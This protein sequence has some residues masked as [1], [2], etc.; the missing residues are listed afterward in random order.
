MKN[1]LLQH[2]QRLRNVAAMR[3]RN[4]ESGLGCGSFAETENHTHYLD[5][6]FAPRGA[7]AGE[8][9]AYPYSESVRRSPLVSFSRLAAMLL[10]LITMGICNALGASVTWEKVTSAP[11]DWSGEYLIVYN[12]QAYDGSLTSNFDASNNYQSV[13]IKDGKITLDDTYSF[14]LAAVTGGYSLQNAAGYYLGRNANSNGMDNA[15]TYNS[16]L[17]ITITWSSTNKNAKLA[18]KGGRCLGNNSGRWRFF[19]SSNAYVNVDLYKKAAT[20]S[21]KVALTKGE[22]N[23]GSFNCTRKKLRF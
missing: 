20:C 7:S 2:V 16:N 12:S 8:T 11:S 13:T 9:P 3:V 5:A 1:N 18:S 15:T 23:N 19:A 17:I 4:S 6:G 14:T 10:L 21:N 22:E